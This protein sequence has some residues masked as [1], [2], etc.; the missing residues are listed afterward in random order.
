MFP[1]RVPGHLKSDVWCTIVA[2]QYKGTVPLIS[3]FWKTLYSMIFKQ[4]ISYRPSLLW[5]CPHRDH[6]KGVIKIRRRVVSCFSFKS[7]GRGERPII[8]QNSPYFCL[9]KYVRA[10]SQ[11]RLNIACDHALSL[12]LCNLFSSQRSKEAKKKI[13]PDLRLGW[14]RRARLG[15][16]AKKFFSRLTR[17]MLHKYMWCLICLVPPVLVKVYDVF[18]G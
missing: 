14:K 17:P 9:F 13:T 5:F 15:R 18:H 6:R 7:Y 1:V 8:L 10:R 16:G 4:S 3:I 2:G 12:Y 11:K